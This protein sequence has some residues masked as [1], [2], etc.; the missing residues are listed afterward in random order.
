MNLLSAHGS[1]RRVLAIVGGALLLLASLH[2]GADNDGAPSPAPEQR[3]VTLHE[4][5]GPNAE[6]SPDT[7]DGD[8]DPT[9]GKTGT[10]QDLRPIGT[11]GQATN[12]DATR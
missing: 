11:S 7:A 10:T 8:D 9:I 12:D 2:C 5:P 1:P 3:D 6:A 4:L